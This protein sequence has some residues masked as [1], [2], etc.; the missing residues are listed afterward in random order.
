MNFFKTIVFL[1]FLLLTS[2]SLTSWWDFPSQVSEMQL[3]AW[4]YG[5]IIDV[6]G[7]SFKHWTDIVSY[8]EENYEIDQDGNKIFNYKS[9]LYIGEVNNKPIS[10]EY[11]DS[12][13]LFLFPIYDGDRANSTFAI[14]TTYKDR[15]FSSSGF[16]SFAIIEQ[17]V[18][19]ESRV[20]RPILITNGGEISGT[21]NNY[22]ILPMVPDAVAGNFD[23]KKIS[24]ELYYLGEDGR[25]H[26]FGGQKRLG[27]F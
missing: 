3:N 26:M 22:I 24:F 17:A 11:L 23:I 21:F 20:G 25:L 15:R 5:D 8:A 1:L 4:L 16:S 18:A 27:S 19:N 7:G 6:C 14:I 2:C 12:T 9:I 10:L 13:Q